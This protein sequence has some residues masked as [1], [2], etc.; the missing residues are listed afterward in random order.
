LAER[1]IWEIYDTQDLTKPH[2]EL[3]ALLPSLIVGPL[4]SSHTNASQGFLTA[5]FSGQFKGIPTPEVVVNAV[6]VRD[7]ANAHCI[8]LVLKNVDNERI[9]ISAAPIS[10]TDVFG[11]L[12]S[13]FPHS[14]IPT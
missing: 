8:A 11:W 3:V 4:L 2:T 12:H 1:K 10:Y 6:D 5:A 14:P 9:T 7:V 13:E